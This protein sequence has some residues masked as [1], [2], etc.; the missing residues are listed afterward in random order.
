M[1]IL[2]A[3]IITMKQYVYIGVILL[4]LLISNNLYAQ[5]K[6]QVESALLQM[7]PEEIDKRIKEAG[8]TREQAVQLARSKGVDLETYLREH[9]SAQQAGEKRD[10][11]ENIF[12]PIET[13]KLEPQPGAVKAEKANPVFTG[14][15]NTNEIVPFGYSIFNLQ[16]SLFEPIL[17]IPTPPSY[18][19]GPGDELVI[20]VWGDTKLFHQLVINREGSIIIPDVG[21]V[22]VNG[23]TIQQ[24]R[25]K[26]LKRMSEVYSSLRRGQPGA[27]SFLDVSLGKL[28]TI[29]IFVLGEVNKP[30]GYSLSSLS[31]ILHALYLAGGPNTNGSLRS[32]HLIRN[33]KLEAQL[34]FYEYALKGERSNDTRLQDGDIVFIPP[35]SK[36]VAIVGSVFRSAIYELK[37]NETLKDLLEYSGGL[38]VNAYT[39]RIH[40]ERI[41]PF[42]LRQELK[43]DILDLDI[44]FSSKNELV[45]S[46]LKLENG[47][48]ITIF[49]ITNY[50]YNRVTISG[51]V[52]KPG[53]YEF[54]KGMRVSDLIM[55]ADSFA[56]NTFME[57]ATLLRLLPNLRK[58]IIQ[59]SPKR[60]LAM[61][62]TDNLVLENED[63][64]IIYRESD[65]F[66]QRYVYIEGAVKNPGQ[67]PRF[68]KMTVADLV[69]LAGGLREDAN[70][71][72]WEL[73]RIDTT[74]VEKYSVVNRFDVSADYWDDDTCKALYL[75]DFD[76]LNIPKNP[77]FTYQQKV[78]IT[79]YAMLPGVYT[80]THK[81]EK[82]YDI[83]NRAG[84]FKP[85]AYI[86]GMRLYRK[87]IGHKKLVP[88]DF[89]KVVSN[90]RSEYNITLID[91]DS[92][93]I[94][95]IT[96]VVTVVGEVFTPANVLYEKNSSLSYY[97]KQA[98]GLTD[99]ADED[100]I[101]VELPNG[102]K[103]ERGWFILPDPDIL[104][105]STIYVPK[106]IEKEN[107][108][109]PLIRDWSTILLSI[110]TM[111][112]AIVQIT[113]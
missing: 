64:I 66:P 37:E 44:T 16:S 48:V 27:T 80:L 98:G 89:D 14:R 101:Y 70:L 22:L 45:N 52:N 57:K 76:V 47:D 42:E 96:N 85:E 41:V 81:D 95:K 99:E 62:T 82:L 75:E 58:E 10:S 55:K 11:G 83:L 51:N 15:V 87:S 68:E 40:I 46:N 25:D 34:D 7:T 94:P 112:V 65:Y 18:I 61:D 79:G 67:Y 21:P 88:L 109:L 31:T 84:G 23:L 3:G 20:S 111:M 106:K 29:Q 1:K 105:G 72:N 39:D 74:K 6:A 43:K 33:N 92:I 90:P 103:W 104:P 102:R 19:V 28:R 73:S 36:R 8:L 56:R 35:V 2:F 54:H 53:I 12:M 77:K 17:N 59:F 9:T 13:V 63:E 86:K 71:T 107:K 93:H 26:L 50:F 60:A 32:I 108:T 30:G 49:N 69:V 78:F 4:G 38:L 113:K 110:A 100:R 97:L 24:I 91:G 5:T